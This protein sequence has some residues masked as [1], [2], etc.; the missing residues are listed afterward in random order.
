MI[1]VYVLG[2]DPPGLV[3]DDDKVLDL[4]SEAE[5]CIES[6]DGVPVGAEFLAAELTDLQDDS[7]ESDPIRE[8][9]SAGTYLRCVAHRHDGKLIDVE[10]VQ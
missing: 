7:G 1:T 6:D 4:M 10:V 3:L 9:L 5:Y 8:R 2:Y